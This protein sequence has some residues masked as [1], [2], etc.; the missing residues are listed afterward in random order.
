MFYASVYLLIERFSLKDLCILQANVWKNSAL[1]MHVCAHNGLG[2][3]FKMRN[4]VTRS[5]CKGGG[6][7]PSN[8]LGKACSLQQLYWPGFHA[9]STLALFRP[10]PEPAF[11][12]TCL[13]AIPRAL[14]CNKCFCG[15][16]TDTHSTQLP[17]TLR[18]VSV[19]CC[20][21]GYWVCPLGEELAQAWASSLSLL[22]PL[23]TPKSTM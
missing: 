23:P 6:G 19:Y 9:Q 3:R 17:K 13:I 2:L 11:G 22:F 12:V 20:S 10:P 15:V 18:E 7:N 14:T 8:C 5:E 16:L 21:L 1:A 4:E